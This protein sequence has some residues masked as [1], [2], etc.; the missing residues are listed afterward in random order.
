MGS[1]PSLPE[2]SR[3]GQDERTRA[4]LRLK[5]VDSQQAV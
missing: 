4:S 5:G 1:I 2:S 3:R